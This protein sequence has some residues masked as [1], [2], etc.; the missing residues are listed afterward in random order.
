MSVPEDKM[1]PHDVEAEEACLGAVII[2]PKVIPE[3]R[4]WLAPG[5]FYIQKNAWILEAIYRLHDERDAIDFVSIRA[6]LDAAGQLEEVGG[7]AYMTLLINSVPTFTHVSTYARIIYEKWVRRNLIS[8]ASDIA[9]SAYREDIPLSEVEVHAQKAVFEAASIKSSGIQTMGAV[10]SAV[11][12]RTEHYHRNPIKDGEAR[13]PDTGYPDL[14]KLTGGWLPG[15][16]VI[17][18]EAFSGK[19]WLMLHSSVLCCK[20]GNRGIFF[21]LEQPAVELGVR[22][23]LARLKIRKADYD[24]G[25]L[26]DD[27][28]P[29]LAA[30]LGK[31]GDNPLL[32]CDDEYSLLGISSRIR[33]EHDKSPLAFA[34]VD[35]L[36]NVSGV[37]EEKLNVKYGAIVRHFH[38]LG[39]ELGTCILLPHHVGSKGTA[40][41]GGKKDCPDSQ[42]PVIGRPRKSSAYYSDMIYH[43]A[44]RVYGLY[45]PSDYYSNER[46]KRRLDVICLKDKYGQS[47]IGQACSFFFGLTGEI[48]L[49][50]HEA[51]ARRSAPPPVEFGEDEDLPYWHK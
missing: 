38:L 14:N 33:Q 40:F 10:I 46:F 11:W 12:E 2:N 6:T 51:E 47:G 36:A 24:R 22:L 29:R 1:M 39:L 18:G 48:Q 4:A 25:N 23:A 9:Q 5:C 34:V 50:D 26:P 21:S 32:I 7:A 49:W 3:I 27:V 43:L 13:G 37:R 17:L 16:T 30:E 19:S 35:C 8:A 28:Y 31:L 44:D 45:R 42:N 15:V 41:S 20:A